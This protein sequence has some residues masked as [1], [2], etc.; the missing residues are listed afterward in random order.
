[1]KNRYIIIISVLLLIHSAGVYAQNSCSISGTVLDAD[2]ETISYATAVLYDGDKIIAGTLSDENG[3]FQLSTGRSSG[4]LTLSVEYLGYYRKDIGV[5][6]SAS[7]VTLGNIVLE[8]NSRLLGETVVTSV[9]EPQKKAVER[10]SINAAANIK[11]IDIITNPD[12]SYDAGGSKKDRN[13]CRNQ[14]IGAG[15]HQC[16]Q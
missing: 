14:P 8:E 12:A 5:S 3:R 6:V 7:S 4:K 10:T 2:G 15:N 16:M 13:H 9:T 1:M 11:T